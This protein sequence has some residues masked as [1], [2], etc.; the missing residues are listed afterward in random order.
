MKKDEDDVLKL[1]SQFSKY[2]VFRQTENLVVI[3]TGDVASEEVKQDL[4]EAEKKG[5]RKLQKF[6]QER[7][8]HKTANFHDTIKQQKLKTFETLHGICTSWQQQESHQGRQ[9]SFEKSRSSVRIRP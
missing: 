3:T 7:L 6:I 8:I 1:V 9:G 4:L 5:E 2:E